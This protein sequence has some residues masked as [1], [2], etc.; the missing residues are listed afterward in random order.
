V[1]HW[2]HGV[3]YIASEYSPRS[4]AYLVWFAEYGVIKAG[5]NSPGSFRVATWQKH[6]ASVLGTWSLGSED[7]ARAV[8]QLGIKTARQYGVA[9]WSD[10]DAPEFIAANAGGTEC[11]SLDSDGDAL[12][13]LAAMHGEATKVVAV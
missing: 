9:C 10:R 6:G 12:I 11:T 5:I 8:E 4:E 13:V 2:L 7:E 1:N 3:D